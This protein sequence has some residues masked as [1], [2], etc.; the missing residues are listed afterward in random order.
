MEDSYNQE[1]DRASRGRGQLVSLRAVLV[2][3]VQGMGLRP[4]SRL[5]FE[6]F[7]VGVE[8]AFVDPPHTAP[9]YLDRGELARAD[10]GVDLGYRNAQITRDVLQTEV[11]GLKNRSVVGSGILRHVG[12]IALQERFDKDL[13]SFA[14]GRAR[15][16]ALALPCPGPRANARA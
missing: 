2:A 4:L 6:V 14:C 11:A 10:E 8:L 7:E 16:L 12:S 9:P 1:S 13:P 3:G 15:D 5:F